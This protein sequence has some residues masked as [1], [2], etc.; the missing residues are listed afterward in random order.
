MVR[1]KTAV[2]VTAMVLA[3]SVLA[4]GSSPASGARSPAAAAGA[5]ALPA[6][7]V[8][9]FVTNVPEPTA[10]AF[11]PD[12][13]LLV[14]TQSGTI[15]VVRGGT[16]LPTPALDHTDETCDQS[17]RGMLGIAVDPKFADN[18]W[19]YV[20]YTFAE[21]GQCP[22]SSATRP[23]N[24]VSRF[25]LPD[26][27]VIDDA[28]EVVL[29]D[30]MPS[31][32]GNHNAGDV[33]I[34]RDGNLYVTIG[35]GGCDYAGD[36]GCQDANDAA[37]DM[38]VLAGKVLR[39]TRQGDIPRSNPFTGGGT[40]RCG[41]TGRTTPGTI[42]R[43]IFATGL[44]NPFRMGFDPNGRATRFFV[45]D[46]GGGAW[47]EIDEGRAGADYGWNVR[48]G[49]CATGSTTNCGPPP[50]GMTNPVWDYS[51]D[52]GCHSIT[53]GAFVPEG[54]WPSKYHG[55]YLYADFGCDRIFALDGGGATQFGLL[56]DGPT[57]LLFDPGSRGRSLYYTTYAN[58]GEVRRV[59]Y[60]G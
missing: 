38:N 40:A 30:D 46:V 58:G 32:G 22:F 45:N 15:R 60:T 43:E 29:L 36:S 9:R 1:R 2:A 47:E 7:F 35:D 59:A 27:N 48:E 42:C 52:T 39:I 25:T 6:G 33:K 10:L 18:H 55:D 50:A 20:F 53:G 13:R 3:A 37:R 4:G 34:G 12:G 23:D 26:S 31:F 19:I 51:H 28:S 11:T 16:L 5:A 54:V 24:R 56:A 44:R 21:A 57:F 41:R 17:E 14:T 49:H 8:D